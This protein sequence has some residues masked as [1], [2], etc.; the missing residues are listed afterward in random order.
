MT[1]GIVTLEDVVEELIGEQIVDE[2]D[3]VEHNGDGAPVT[4]PEQF[5]KMMN[6]AYASLK[7]QNYAAKE[8]PEKVPPRAPA[9]AMMGR[10]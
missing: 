5:D 4:G 8:A 9:A 1:V 3:Y 6:M 2:T 10:R 7:W